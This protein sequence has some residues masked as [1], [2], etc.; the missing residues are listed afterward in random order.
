MNKYVKKM[1][2]EEIQNI[3]N[4][5]QTIDQYNL[6]TNTNKMKKKELIEAHRSIKKY[7]AVKQTNYREFTFS[8]RTIKLNDEQYRVV[9]AKPNQNIRVIACA[10][11][12]KT[13]TIIC[14]IKYLIDQGINPETIMLTTFNVDANE[15]MKNKIIDL[16]GFLPKITIGTIDSIACRFYYRF[17][18]QNFEVGVSEYTSYLLRYLNS[19][20]GF[21]IYGQYK[22]IFFDEFQDINDIQFQVLNVFYKHG[23]H[24]TVI[25][26]DAQ[27]IY[28]FRGSNVSYILNLEHRFKNLKT[29]KLVNNYRST[30]EIIDLA[31]DS[32]KINTEQLPKDMIPN[33]PSIDFVPT[34]TFFETHNA[35]NYEVIKL[36]LQ[37]KRKGIP[38]DEIAVLCR[39][40]YPLKQLEEAIEEHNHKFVDEKIDYVS[41]ISDNNSDTKP[42]IKK[43]HMTITSIHKSKGLEWTVVFLIDCNDQ[44]FPSETDKISL[45]EERRLFYVATTRAKQYLYFFFCRSK[46]DQRVQLTRFLQEIDNKLYKFTN[47]E[48]SLREYVD[49]R[50]I[51]WITSVTETIQLLNEKDIAILRDNGILPKI[52]P[53]VKK[54]HHEHKLENVIESY[55]LQADFGEFIDRYITRSIGRKRQET[56][57]LI[58]AATIII[59]SKVCFSKQEIIVIKKYYAGFKKNISM[60]K[61]GMD[62]NLFVRA[63]KRD[64]GKLVDLDDYPFIISVLK[65]VLGIATKYDLRIELVCGYVFFSEGIP[66]NIRCRINDS[67]LRYVDQRYSSKDLLNDVYNISLCSTFLGGRRRL[68]YKDVSR[69][70][71]NN[72]KLF[73]DI[74]TYVANLN[75]EGFVCKNLVYSKEFDLV[76]EIDLCSNSK[77]VDFKC[78]SSDNFKLEWLLQLLAYCSIIKYEIANYQEEDDYDGKKL[79]ESIGFL[80]LNSQ[81]KELEI[82]NALKGVLYTIDINDWNKHKEFLAYLKYVRSRQSCRNMDEWKLPLGDEHECDSESNHDH[83][84]NLRKLFGAKIN[85]MWDLILDDISQYKGIVDEFRKYN[86]RRYLVIDVETTGIPAKDDIGGFYK[87]DKLDKYNGARMVQISWAVYEY[88][89]LI[90]TINFI[91]KPNS[92]EIMLSEIHGI[93]H[94]YALNHGTD[95]NVIFDELM[96]DLSIVKYIVGH[97]V[98][99]D[100]NIICSELFRVGKTNIIDQLKSK[101]I[102]CTMEKSMLLRVDGRVGICKL[103]NLYKFLFDEEFD[104]AH[105]A[106]CDVKATCRIFLELVNRDIIQI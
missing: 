12:G 81:I 41:L 5:R 4:L 45:Q 47:D 105:N 54:I 64:V 46:K 39:N 101:K 11:S 67:Y 98:R 10:G 22:Y 53:V 59:C 61:I 89:K 8:N 13:T 52:V 29:Y 2:S 94:Q 19:I 72:H 17:F 75:L 26:D 51:K 14:R 95:I 24:V 87:Y 84:F 48:E 73:E 66:E 15:N 20:N 65:K 7:L 91:V 88:R 42:K 83:I 32:I 69:H 56:K 104:G 77:I 31:N 27:N 63:L 6:V 76:G 50:T 106:E 23:S 70:F 16:F 71:V 49:D 93:E 103:G 90:K 86:D 44:K 79:K 102:L 37:L 38:F 62:C 80:G 1:D 60:I 92:F 78:S 99:F 34:V 96:N 97:N 30:K 57:G 55:Y 82:Y 25:G 33:N 35:Q 40:N 58:D 85:D 9:V 28:Q 18:R 43:G 100:I 21:T 36:V 74:D 68:L 3:N